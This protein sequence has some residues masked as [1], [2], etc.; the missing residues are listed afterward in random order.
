MSISEPLLVQIVH[1]HIPAGA[2][3]V[4]I[5]KPV[6][7][8]AIYAADLTGDGIPEI[9]TVYQLNGE[10]YLLV[11]KFYNGQWIKMSLTKGLGYRVTLL[12]A[13]PVTS[14]SRNNLIVGWQLGA[15][16]SKLAVY[17]WTDSGLKDLS[18][19]DVVFSHAEII[20]MPGQHGRDGKVEIALWI[21]DTGEAYRVD[22]IRWQNGKWVSAPDVYPYY[23]PKVVQYYE[24]LTQHYPDYI[25]YWSYLAD[26]QYK[27]GMFP[28]ALASVQKALSFTDPYPSK[29]ALLALEKS[30]KQAM[31]S[32]SHAREV[33]WLYPVSVRTVHGTRWGY[34]DEQGHI[35]LEPVLDDARDFQPNGLAVVVQNGKAGVINLNGQFVVQPLYD[36]INSYVEGRAIVID[37]QGFKMIDEQGHVLTRRAY[38]FIADLSDGRALF[39][40][41]DSSTGGGTSKYGYLDQSGQEAIKAQFQSAY[42]FQQG[43]AVV[44]IKENEY[45]LIDLNGNRLATYPYPY[46]GPLGDGM[47]AFQKE[48]AGKYGYIDERGNIIIQPQFSTALPF[49]NGLAIVNTS[50]DYK[51]TYGVINRQGQFVIQPTYNDIR[52]LGEQRFALGQAIDPE[53][54]YI[55]SFYAIADE[56]GKLLSSFTYRDVGQFKQGLLSASDGKRTYLLDRSGQPAPGY[57][58]VEGSGTLE[59]VAPNLIKAFVDQ[60]LSYVNRSGQVIWKQNTIVPLHPPY[61][62]REEKYKPNPDYLVYYPQ[63]E[64]MADQAAQLGVN[65][66]L[67]SLSQV[68]PIPAD[69]KLDYSY[70][71]DFD[72]TFYKQQLLQLQLTGYN[73]PF[74]AAHGMPTMIYAIINL[75]NGRMYELKDLFKPNS[76]YVKVLSRI[77]ADQ[78]KNDPQYSYVFPDTYEGISPD[79][80]FFVTADALHLYFAPYEIA[81]YAAGFPTFN[82]PFIQIKD[83][84]NTEG[85]FWK[86]FHM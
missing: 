14:T 62:V 52:E 9:A 43:K 26:A 59:V 57:P 60:R 24:K 3:V 65:A 13:A 38:P 8:P 54:P 46:V 31:E 75:T 5:D 6:K 2:T 85:E 70:T 73:Y 30:I 74:G 78:I 63:V 47:L 10:L 64:G 21:H 80:P 42:D 44:Q 29:E 83:I 50:A 39:Y 48:T 22:I 36:S 17:D 56:S 27:A 61:R 37:A 41:T 32:G 40:D 51:S 49:H 25:F 45:A 69:Q 18:P 28:A 58:Q 86:A 19:E 84:I 34:M 77:V 81:P 68:K 7:H 67:K 55:G 71:G 35:R 12:T 4:T 20:D 33:T 79:Q 11:L 82:I 16:W 72:I 53:Q 1:Q 76:D 66:K 15:I 23:F